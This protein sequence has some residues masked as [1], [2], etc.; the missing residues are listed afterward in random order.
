[1]PFTCSITNGIGAGFLA[2][3][4]PR[5]LAGRIRELHPLMRGASVA[6]QVYFALGG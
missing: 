2:F 3:V 5:L 1:M 6:F 4:V